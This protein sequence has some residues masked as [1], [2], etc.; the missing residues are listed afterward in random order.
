ME[1]QA[2]RHDTWSRIAQSFMP[3]P[4]MLARGARVSYNEWRKNQHIP[5]RHSRKISCSWG[6]IEVQMKLSINSTGFKFLEC[7]R[8]VSSNEEIPWQNLKKTRGKKLRPEPSD[9]GQGFLAYWRQRL[10]K[11]DKFSKNEVLS[12]KA[13]NSPRSRRAVS[14]CIPS[15][16]DSLPIF[17]IYTE[18]T[19]DS[20]ELTIDP[21]ITGW[22]EHRVTWGFTDLATN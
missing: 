16:S 18:R 10:S 11:I 19:F 12:S 20:L 21:S 6:M 2:S 4:P 9:A 1:L 5:G 22:N 3:P 15:V 8:T 13:V 14:K 7:P 17:F